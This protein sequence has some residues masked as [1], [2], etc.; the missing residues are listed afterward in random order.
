LGFQFKIFRNN[1][2]FLTQDVAALKEEATYNKNK[3]DEWK[4]TAQS[5]EDSLNLSEQERQGNELVIALLETLLYS[6]LRVS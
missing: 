4:N 6:Q 3:A 2:K 5:L 1:S